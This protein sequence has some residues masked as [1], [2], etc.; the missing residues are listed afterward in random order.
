MTN[1]E[2]SYAQEHMVAKYMGWRVVSGSGARPFAPGDV[3]SDQ[4]IVECK[5]HINES[6]VQFLK[7]H[8]DK[9]VIE[10]RSKTKIPIL[11][12]DNGTQQ[13][14]CSWVM[15]PYNIVSNCTSPNCIEGLPNNSR[16][17]NTITFDHDSAYSLYMGN[18]TS[19][20]ISVFQVRWN[21]QDPP[22]AI[23]TLEAFRQFF[24]EQFN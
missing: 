2:A 20:N 17:G 22:L 15:I 19:N 14:R 21:D 5:T 9:I 6:K 10:A 13:S 3:I 18:C 16:S 24:E 23:L 1:K 12:T 8:W 11:I 4:F 7:N